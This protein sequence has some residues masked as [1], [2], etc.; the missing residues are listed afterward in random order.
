MRHLVFEGTAGIVEKIR[1]DSPRILIEMDSYYISD[2]NFR[3]LFN[4]YGLEIQMFG[5]PNYFI[6]KR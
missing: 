5:I 3:P 1:A 6:Y 4:E 2:P